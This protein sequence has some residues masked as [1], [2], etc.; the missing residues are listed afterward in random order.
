M[1]TN[2]TTLK[3]MFNDRIIDVE[4]KVTAVTSKAA[5]PYASLVMMRAALPVALVG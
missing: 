1:A 3:R 4:N 2:K 5:L